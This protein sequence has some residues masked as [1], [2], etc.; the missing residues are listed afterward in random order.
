VATVVLSILGH[1]P[2]ANP[3]AVAFGAREKAESGAG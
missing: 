2:T 1:G 3:L